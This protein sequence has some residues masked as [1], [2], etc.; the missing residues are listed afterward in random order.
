MYGVSWY[1]LLALHRF[2]FVGYVFAFAFV[3]YV[4]AFAFVGYVAFENL[5]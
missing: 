5:I 4:F 1:F 2:V 3:G